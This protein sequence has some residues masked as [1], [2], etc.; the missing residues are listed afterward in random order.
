[1]G[2]KIVQQCRGIIIDEADD[3]KIICRIFDKF[4]NFSEGHAAKIDFENSRIYE[5]V[6][7]SLCQLYYYDGEWRV[8]TS[9]SPDAGGSVGDFNK[10]F[11][12]LFWETW[13]DL[14]YKLPDDTNISY[15]FELLTPYNTIVVQHKDSTIALLGARNLV[16][17]KELNPIIESHQ[18]GWQCVKTFDF[19]DREE[20][21]K[22][23]KGMNGSE[24]EGFV[25]CDINSYNRVKMKCEDYVKKHRLVSCMSQRNMLDA[26]RTNEGDEILLYAPQFE[27]LFWEIKC[28]YERLVGRIEGFY[29][30]TKHIEDKKEFALLV[31]DQKFSGVLFGLRHGKINSIR[32]GIAD[33]NI[34]QLEQWLGMKLKE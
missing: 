21:E 10:T 32:Q 5:K 4:F 3:Y 33:M 2:N 27:K 1:M 14:N 15:A 23:L 6:D 30:A 31:K 18:N 17:Q 8:S 7:G 22:I 26:V 25:V 9:G 19:E 34:K 29:D 28:N 24:Q 11:K 16:T 13:S 20:I 12:E